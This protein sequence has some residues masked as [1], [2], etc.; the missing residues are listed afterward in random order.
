MV[1]PEL[2]QADPL[3][4][5][6]PS[7]RTALFLSAG[8]MPIGSSS[9]NGKARGECVTVV[10]GGY[11]NANEKLARQSIGFQGTRQR[12]PT[13]LMRRAFLMTV[14]A[15]IL[16]YPAPRHDP[17]ESRP[18]K[19][20]IPVADLNRSWD[21]PATKA[22]P[23]RPPQGRASGSEASIATRQRRVSVLSWPSIAATGR[24]NGQGFSPGS[25]LSARWVSV[26]REG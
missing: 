14:R 3:T 4:R 13:S 18:L 22:S 9:P 10:P 2:P 12:T 23:E 25:P 7:R 1:S 19:P 21:K 6:A 11:Q 24:Y 16:V 26:I 8:W 17:F 5:S 15:L 20:F